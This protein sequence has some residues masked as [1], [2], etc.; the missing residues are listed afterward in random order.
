MMDVLT[1]IIERALA[2]QQAEHEAERDAAVA[3][4]LERAAQRINYAFDHELSIM[5]GKERTH[6]VTA[7]RALA[8]RS[9]LV[10]VPVKSLLAL[11][12]ALIALADAEA[13]KEGK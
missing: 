6:L 9:D 1:N 10:C 7:I 13:D 5:H 8:P 12:K 11:R 3:E 2:A 4:A